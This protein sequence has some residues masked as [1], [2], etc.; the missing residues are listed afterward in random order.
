LSDGGK[1]F[2]ELQRTVEGISARV[3][4][5]ELKELEMNGFIKRNIY[6]ST[7]V[8]VEYERTPYSATLKEVVKALSN[9]GAMH[10]ENIKQRSRKARMTT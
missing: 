7:P 5:N 10:R 1:R 4:S 3:L 8:A 2:N 9:W 6:D